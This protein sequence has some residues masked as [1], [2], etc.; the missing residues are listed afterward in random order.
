MHFARTRIRTAVSSVLAL[1]LVVT[2]LAAAPAPTAVAKKNVPAKGVK[3]VIVLISDGMGYSQL[4]A[5]NLYETGARVAQPYEHFPLR[6][7]MATYSASGNEYDPA[8]AWSDFN[9]VKGGATDSASAATAMSTGVKTY[10]AGIGVDFHGQPVKHMME[11]AEDLGK[12]TGVVSSVQ[13]SHATSAGFV[14]H[15]VSRN[16]YSGIALEMIHDSAVDVIMGAG[17]PL[18]TDNATPR[19]TPSYRYIGDEAT[20]NG[21][22]AGTVGG[23][24]DGDGL[25]DAWTLVQSREEFQ[26]MA[27]GDTPERVI[28]L[29]MVHST[30]QQARSGNG[31]ADPY[32]VPF[33]DGVP[34]L[35][36]M[37]SAALN[38]LDD[39]ENGL[40]L[41]VEGGAVDWAGHGNQTGRLIEEQADFN[42]MV[43]V[44]IEWV[45]QNSNWGETLV[46]VTGD[47][48]TGYLTGP[49]S[50]QTADGAEYYPLVNNGAGNVPGVQWNSGNHTNSLIPIFA[51]GS[52]SRFLR[53]RLSESDPVRG[54]Y[55][56]NTAIAEV[57][58]AV[59]K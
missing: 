38:V 30:L 37:A 17:H 51:K 6:A 10:D 41:M 43:D 48:E 18:Y 47:H 49:G 12:S 15:N 56:D 31:Y 46:I 25:P 21:L 33:T 2:V 52:A 3:N 45:E 36:E 1:A 9:Y 23:D 50:G 20:W 59:M 13:I 57:A 22:V 53:D 55:L 24:A 44:V 39:N 4:E 54:R 16:D 7:G 35:P 34:T 42:A 27:E 32:E 40:V 8:L 58:I 5:A 14:A 19:T 28:G 29:P 26:M 11:Y